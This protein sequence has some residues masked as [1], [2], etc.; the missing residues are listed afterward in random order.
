M[1]QSIHMSLIASLVQPFLQSLLHLV[2]FAPAVHVHWAITN[3][4]QLLV[5]G[6]FLSI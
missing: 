2:C 3:V 5:F 6:K 4:T 1:P